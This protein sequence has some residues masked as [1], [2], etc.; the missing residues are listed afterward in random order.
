MTEYAKGVVPT[1]AGMLL[2]GLEPKRFLPKAGITAVAYPGVEKDYATIEHA[3]LRGPLVRLASQA[4]DEV[5]GGLSDQAMYFIHR[6]TRV[7]ATLDVTRRVDRR[8][9]PDDAVREALLN[10]LIHR[11]YSI[12]GTDVELSLYSDRLEV[13]SPGRLP[14]TIT[15]ER[16]KAGCRFARNELLKETM[17]DY[18]YVES[19]G[20]GI[21]R[22]MLKSAIEHGLPE[23]E[24]IEEETRFIVRLRKRPEPA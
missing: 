16:M 5:E 10:A 24:L 22:R 20:M 23:P 6:N 12:A 17:R 18:G 1:L 4:G 3:V 2:F 7:T 9:Y 13:I 11:D 8:E 21:P 19:R 15:V 14:N